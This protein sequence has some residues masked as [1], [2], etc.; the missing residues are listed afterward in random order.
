MTVHCLEIVTA[1]NYPAQDAKDDLDA[2]RSNRDEWQDVDDADLKRR[3]TIEG[4][5]DHYH[6]RLR[7]K[8]SEP[9]SDLRDVAEAWLSANFDWWA[10]RYHA[11]EHDGDKRGRGGCG[12]D[13]QNTS[14]NVPADVIQ[15]YA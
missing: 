10:W 13:A 3:R 8:W 12:W 1:T 7:F 14:G 5:V 9:L 15:E 11:C 4:G 2:F 6:A